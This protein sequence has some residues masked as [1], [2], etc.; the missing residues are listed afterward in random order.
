MVHEESP[1]TSHP[2]SAS[3]LGTSVVPES[4]GNFEGHSNISG[5]TFLPQDSSFEDGEPDP[6]I[7]VEELPDLQS[8]ANRLLDL[9]VSNA[10]DPRN[11]LDSAKRI[12]NPRN[13][14]S[15]RLK[16]A[17]RKLVSTMNGFSSQAFIDV[18]QIKQM[19]PSVRPPGAARPWSPLPILHKANCARLALDVLLASIGSQSPRQAVERLERQFPT[20]FL[21]SIVKR[22]QPKPVGASTAEKQTF[23]LALEIR[24]Q[25]FIMELER[26]QSEKDFD[27]R[28][29]LKGVFYDELALEEDEDPGSLRG[30]KLKPIFEDENGRLPDR[31]QD[32]VIDRVSELEYDLFDQDDLLNIQSLKRASWTRFVLR[33][34][35]F[36]HSRDKEILFDLQQQPKIDEV[37]DLVRKEI[38]RRDDPA[39]HDTPDRQA[40]TVPE[41]EDRSSRALLPRED[42]G[43]PR[44]PSIHATPA[45]NRQSLASHLSWGPSPVRQR[46]KTTSAQSPAPDLH[47]RKSL[48]GYVCT[49]GI[50]DG[51]SDSWP[52]RANLSRTRLMPFNDAKIDIASKKCHTWNLSTQAVLLHKKAALSLLLSR[53]RIHK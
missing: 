28:S 21:N 15:K 46:P 25:Y 10:S 18:A 12:T 20:P 36:I 45:Q 53:Q 23:E 41:T 42:L 43:P 13:T 49:L 22:S 26:R 24:T 33:T 37:E 7:L 31:Y 9:F 6:I 34:A 47:R 50:F 38:E 52:A 16:L 29:I 2:S 30:F 19:I 1:A 35:R 8:A 5:T 17:V 27:P 11:I 44:E 4:P 51:G 48:K 39:S 32:D 40:E 14:D 3:R